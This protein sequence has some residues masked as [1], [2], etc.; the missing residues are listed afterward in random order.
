MNPERP[1]TRTDTKEKQ[2]DAAT[3]GVFFLWLGISFLAHIPWGAWLLG[4]GVIVL[5]A[6]LGRRM[7]GA[8]LDAF[9]LVA[10][11]LFVLGGIS[12]I[13]PFGLHVAVIPVLCIVVG[14]VLLAKALTRSAGPRHA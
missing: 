6:Q 3:W 2:L 14:I 7:L 10:G 9:W 1:I 12:D 11:V 13:V 8:R 4:V 5:G